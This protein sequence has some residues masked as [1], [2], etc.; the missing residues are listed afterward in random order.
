M[1]LYSGLFPTINRPI[2]YKLLQYIKKKCVFRTWL[3]NILPS[4]CCCYTSTLFTED[5]SCSAINVLTVTWI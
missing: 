4:C 5:V 1:A 3:F 2:L